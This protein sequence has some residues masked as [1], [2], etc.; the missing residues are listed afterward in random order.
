MSDLI[1]YEPVEKA[2]R[3]KR[4]SRLGFLFL[5]LSMIGIALYVPKFLLL[6]KTLRL[7]EDCLQFQYSPG[8]ITFEGDSSKAEKLLL[9]DHSFLGIKVPPYSSS[10][11]RFV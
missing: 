3:R 1:E 2:R 6:F 10:P 5:L 11:A 4:G 8:T 9:A 7:Q